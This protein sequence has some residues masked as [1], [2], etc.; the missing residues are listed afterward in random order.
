MINIVK[1]SY[2]FDMEFVIVKE[3]MIMHKQKYVNELLDRLTM[4]DSN[5]ITNSYECKAR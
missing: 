1:L 4:I 3:D 5:T 2:F